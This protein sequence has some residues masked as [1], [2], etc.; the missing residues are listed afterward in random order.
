MT[1][2]TLTIFTFAVLL[3]ISAAASYSYA[4]S[5]LSDYMN[6]VST[7]SKGEPMASGSASSISKNGAY[8]AFK[9]TGNSDNFDDPGQFNVYRKDLLTGRIKKA[10]LSLDDL[11]KLSQNYT[12]STSIYLDDPPPAISED[13]RYIAFLAWVMNVAPP[14][15][16][17][18]DMKK[19][20]F[21]KDMDTGKIKVAATCSSGHTYEP[22]SYAM[23]PSG[24]FIAW[25]TDPS[26]NNGDFFL[27]D[28]NTGTQRTVSSNVY[29]EPITAGIYDGND[30]K[31]VSSNGTYVYFNSTSNCF[32]PGDENG[33]V[34][35]FLKN[36]NTGEVLRV[37]TGVYHVYRDQLSAPVKDPVPT[38][39]RESAD[40][41]KLQVDGGNVVD[42]TPNGRYSLL[43]ARN[44]GLLRKDMQTG[45]MELA[46]DSGE[47]GGWFGIDGLDGHSI[48]S[49]GRYVIFT[50][51]YSNLVEK[52][53]NNT[54]DVFRKDMLTGEILRVNI[55]SNGKQVAS[56]PWM[57]AIS[58]S[59]DGH[60][61]SFNSDVK[62]LV[63]NKH[64]LYNVY[65]ADMRK[66]PLQSIAQYLEKTL[67]KY[68]DDKTPPNIRIL[69]PYKNRPVLNKRMVWLK[70]QA[71]DLAS[72]LSRIMISN[73]NKTWVKKAANALINW[74]VTEGD[75]VKTIYVKA[76]DKRGNTSIKSSSVAWDQT[77]PRAKLT[78]PANNSQVKGKLTIEIK[79]RDP[80]VASVSS[81]VRKIRI[82][83]N[84]KV[85]K[86]TTNS[87]LK[88][89][90]DTKKL[91][92]GKHYFKIRVRDK[93]G[94]INEIKRNYTVKN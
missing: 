30:I 34:D 27:K 74:K 14:H 28:L 23:D 93:V 63:L 80:L 56:K 81:G 17:T 26:G 65:V 64:K 41:E 49:D 73:D 67:P 58:S 72:G 7:N 21:R 5:A 24:R 55:S 88:Y 82:F 71:N 12:N 39:D 60:L 83:R 92:N 70:I 79:A 50:S 32:V 87:T 89:E 25:Q 54:L 51:K 76:I 11:L 16:A 31:G 68:L 13:G 46:V 91:T 69:K 43:V 90:L 44:I 78:A 77:A 48:S 22:I 42:I 20:I 6:L 4:A 15:G 45:D 33:Q 40:V 86:E 18:T 66:Y 3:S 2:L 9:A 36:M 1:K 61:I 19:V 52:D 37:T 29:R 53:T 62:G 75:G 57:S 59:W 8:V 10:S 35:G 94:N 85:V 38:G 84:N 47:P